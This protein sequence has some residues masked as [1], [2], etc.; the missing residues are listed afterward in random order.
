MHPGAVLSFLVLLNLG[1]NQIAA[2]YFVNVGFKDLS[3]VDASKAVVLEAASTGCIASSDPAIFEHRVCNSTHYSVSYCSDAGCSN[4]GEVSSATVLRT[5]GPSG[6]YN[7]STSCISGDLNISSYIPRFSDTR[8]VNLE[9]QRAS[10]TQPNCSSVT[11]ALYSLRATFEGCIDGGSSN[12]FLRTCN[13]THQIDLTC[14]ADYGLTCSADCV[15]TYVTPLKTCESGEGQLR[16]T[17]SCLTIP[18][19]APTSAPSAAT[20]PTTSGGAPPTANGN[21]A[22]V[23]DS[24]SAPQSAA[25]AGAPKTKGPSSS[26]GSATETWTISLIMFLFIAFAVL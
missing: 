20:A 25:P 16:V 21:T 19:T 10:N 23:A 22:P 2:Q 15:E 17:T 14:V 7:S 5:C 6:E 3:C 9:V 4:C 24:S 13:A 8:R 11:S 26:T 1:A 18:G 12:G